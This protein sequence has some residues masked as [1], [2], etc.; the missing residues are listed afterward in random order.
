[1]SD[2]QS[3]ER[4]MLEALICPQ[5][6]TTLEYDAEA[7]EVIDAAQYTP[8]ILLARNLEP[9]N[10]A[11]P[12]YAEVLPVQMMAPLPASTMAGVARRASCSRAIATAMTTTGSR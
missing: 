2:T 3:F 10:L 8:E 4:R 7:G 1:M 11:R 9:A 12:R 5:T 6:Q